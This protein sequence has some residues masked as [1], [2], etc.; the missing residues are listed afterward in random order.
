MKVGVIQLGL[1]AAKMCIDMKESV[2]VG[3]MK[4]ACESIPSPFYAVNGCHPV[5]NRTEADKGLGG[6]ATTLREKLGGKDRLF[7]DDEAAKWKQQVEVL[8]GED[9]KKMLGKVDK[10]KQVV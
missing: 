10:S 8:K 1:K 3:L 6:R 2:T 9:D 7:G 5:V 4:K